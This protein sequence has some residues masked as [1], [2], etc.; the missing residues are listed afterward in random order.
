[1][2]TNILWQVIPKDGKLET[3]STHTGDVGIMANNGVT[4]GDGTVNRVSL[5][6]DTGNLKPGEY[7]AVAARLEGDMQA[8]DVRMGDLAGSAGFTLI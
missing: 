2:G 6:V 7:I 4:K 5:A 8:G 3:G 1:V